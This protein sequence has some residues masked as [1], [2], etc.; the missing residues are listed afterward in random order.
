M[1]IEL[2]IGLVFLL[3]IDGPRRCSRECKLMGQEE[4]IL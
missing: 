4:D 2:S 1:I 3:G